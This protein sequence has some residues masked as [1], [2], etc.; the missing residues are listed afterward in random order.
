MKKKAS[1]VPEKIED[2]RKI[3]FKMITFKLIL[4]E[5]SLGLSQSRRRQ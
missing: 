1:C 5:N 2:L 3:V 4:L